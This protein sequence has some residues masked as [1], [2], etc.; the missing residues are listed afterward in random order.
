LAHCRLVSVDDVCYWKQLHAYFGLQ[1]I[2]QDLN[3]NYDIIKQVTNSLMKF[4][5][6]T[7][8]SSLTGTDSTVG[9]ID[10]RYTHQDVCFVWRFFILSIKVCL[11]YYELH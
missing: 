7:C 8:V 3:K 1:S 4:H 2:L 9:S 11:S 5:Q 6:I 10:S